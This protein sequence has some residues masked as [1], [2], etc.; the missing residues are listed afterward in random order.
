[1]EK[2]FLR[3][4]AALQTINLEYHRS[5]FDEID[6][7]NPLIAITG[8]RGV[9][10]TTLLLQKLK[11]L[12]IPSSEGLYVDL[13]DLYFSNNK[14]IDFVEA[15]LS[16]GGKYLFL[17]EVHRYS[18]GSWAEELKRIHDLYRNRLQITFTGS[19]VIQI[20]NRQADLSRR[21]RYYKMYGLSFREFLLLA[22]NIKLPLVELFDL[23]QNHQRIYQEVNPGVVFRPLPRLREYWQYGYYP[24]F[25]EDQKGF[26]QRLN[27]VIQIVIEQDIPYASGVNALDRIAI[28][29]L[30]FAIASSPPFKPNISKL[31]E[32]LG[33]ARNTLVQYLN[34]LDQAELIQGLKSEQKGISAM[35][36]PDKIYLDNTNIIYALAPEQA[37]LGTLRETF[38]FNQLSATAALA[39]QPGGIALPKKGDFLYRSVTIDYLFEVGGPNKS[40]KQIGKSEQ[41]FIVAD[42]EQS[43]NKHRI[44]LWMFGLLY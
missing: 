3:S 35:Q 30:L 26:L 8:A 11:S 31:S 16:L 34:L 36:K 4:Q 13:G 27:Q 37:D 6:W 22:Y 28:G 18:Y 17:D 39:E 38:F 23:L 2:L 9:G 25:L 7:S 29:K 32:R 43:G 42:I 44:P 5:L 20:L 19:S 33:I 10:K 21:V 14:L 12:Q 24:Y 15:Y 40:S 1:M 41:H